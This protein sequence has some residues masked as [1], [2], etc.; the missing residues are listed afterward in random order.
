MRY[1]CCNMPLPITEEMMKNMCDRGVD[2][3]RNPTFC[4]KDFE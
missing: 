4:V 3:C 2:I 1:V